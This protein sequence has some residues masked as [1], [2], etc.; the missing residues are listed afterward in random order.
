MESMH[1]NLFNVLNSYEVMMRL[2]M[3]GNKML[4]NK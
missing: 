1:A 4:N 3:T 2:H